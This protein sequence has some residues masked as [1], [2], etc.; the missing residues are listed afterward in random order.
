[1]IEHAMSKCMY[2]IHPFTTTMTDV[3]MTYHNCFTTA[4]HLALIHYIMHSI[5]AVKN[6]LPLYKMQCNLV[7]IWLL[8]RTRSPQFCS[9]AL[10]TKSLH[11]ILQLKGCIVRMLKDY[12]FL[13]SHPSSM[14]MMIATTTPFTFYNDD[15]R[16]FHPIQF[17]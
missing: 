16:H 5:I 9:H 13:F 7:F 17:W 11:N 2:Y 15:D 3:W 12:D 1:M 8:H 6:T 14:T 4:S 10:Y